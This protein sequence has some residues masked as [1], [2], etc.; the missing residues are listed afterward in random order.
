MFLVGKGNFNKDYPQQFDLDN[1]LSNFNKENFTVVIPV[2]NEEEAIGQVLESVKDCGYYNILVIDGYSTDDTVA[3]ASNNG[4][5]VITQLGIGKTGAIKTAIEHVRTPYLVVMDGDCTYDPRD[6]KNFFPHIRTD[7]EVIGAR[8]YGKDNIPTLNRF[9][10]W[11]I[12]FT[13]NLLFNTN[14]ID[15]CSGMYALKTDFARTL[16]FRTK[17]FDVEVE[18]ASQAANTGLITQVPISYHE[19]V[20][21]QKL[22]P[23]K[24]GLQIITSVWKMAFLYN[25]VF[26]FSLLASTSLIPAIILL[27][28]VAVNWARGVFHAGWALFG[29]LFLLFGII[30]F[31]TGIQSVLFKRMER[32]IIRTIIRE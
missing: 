2:L 4:V 19:R 10:N 27:S 3:I 29:I 32:R 11:I 26:L 22:Q 8:I 21:Q 7:D 13:F 16:N 14:L 5:R 9:G 30:A 18:I 31:V 23:W 17:G 24:H 28:L 6:I 1:T 20:G 12:N 25:P 15:V